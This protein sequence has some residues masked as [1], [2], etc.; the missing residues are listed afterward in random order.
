MTGPTLVLNAGSSS[1]KAAIFE[2][3][4]E[5]LRAEASGIGAGTGALELAG[6]R[7]PR[8]LPDHDAALAA[9]LEALGQAGVAPEGLGAAGHR[10]VQGG[11]ELRAPARLT[12]ALRD[13][14]A[15]CIPLAP[16]H[17]PHNLAAIDALTRRAPDLPQVAC[18]D[19]AFHSGLPELEYRFALPERP[20]TAGLRRYGFH[21]LS[22]AA[23][24]H[25]LPR[26][27][28]AALPRR[29]LALHL[30]SGA[31]ACAILDGR[32][33]ATTMGYSTLDGLPMGSRPGSLDPG[34]V[35]ELARR[36]GIDAAETM[37]NREAGLKGLS[38]LDGD[39]RTLQ[40][41]GTPA[42]GFA[43]AHFCYWT[44]RHCGGLIAA[45][46]GL[47]AIVFTGGIGEHAAAVRNDITRRLSWAGT[48]PVHVLPAAEE[49]QIAR[50]TATVLAGS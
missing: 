47:D 34:A 20:E 8:A 14:I 42:A 3:G 38:G 19:T 37:L 15:A 17:N 5:R 33:V 43:I 23:L 26:R 35:L 27:T 32:S 22:Y 21:G 6:R 39:M 40:A 45:M 49:A 50:E 28:G 24:V 36:M 46:A 13:R 9:L 48:V 29:L 30:G 1:I 2:N 7:D 11:E 10:V 18:F 4:V 31:S 12:P 44:A 25:D 41:A 16:L